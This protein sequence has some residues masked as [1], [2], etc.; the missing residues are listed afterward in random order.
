MKKM[1]Y[2]EVDRKIAELEKALSGGRVTWTDRRGKHTGTWEAFRGSIFFCL[3]G[4]MEKMNREDCPLIS[5]DMDQMSKLPEAQ[6]L[7]LGTL[8]NWIGFPVY[9]LVRLSDGRE[10]YEHRKGFVTLEGENI[11][12]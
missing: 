8:L 4:R 3:L 2:P 11:N 7:G 5:F 12:E 10:V 9:E 6:Q 1:K